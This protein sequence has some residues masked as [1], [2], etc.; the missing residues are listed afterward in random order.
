MRAAADAAEMGERHGHADGPV[1]A[2]AQDA[3]VIEEDHA[4]HAA[5]IDW[6]TEQGTDKDIRA[7]RFVDH[8]GAKG[9]VSLAEKLA[10]MGQRPLPEIRA[11]GGD[12]ARRLATGVGV[13]DPNSLE[14]T[15]HWNLTNPR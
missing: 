8:G 4:G 2:H 10:L 1:A 11:P 14:L 7:A 5:R 12:D 15:G 9:I 3:D 13:D 6:L